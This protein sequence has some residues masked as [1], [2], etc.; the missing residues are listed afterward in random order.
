[1][2]YLKLGRGDRSV[3]QIDGLHVPVQYLPGGHSTICQID[4]LDTP[5]RYLPGGHSTI[6][7]IDCL[8]V[9]VQYLGRS[10]RA[11]RELGT[12]D[13]IILDLDCADGVVL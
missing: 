2:S 3:C 9:P 13:R 1:M 10:Y 6:C 12:G 8:H 11:V 4:C 7:Q 5:I